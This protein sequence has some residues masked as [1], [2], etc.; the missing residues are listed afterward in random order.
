LLALV[1]DA[2]RFDFYERRLLA[3]AVDY[4]ALREDGADDVD[5]LRGFDDDARV[6]GAVCRALG[7]EE[8]VRGF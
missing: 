7:R 2:A 5:H 6:V 1:A 8:L 4:F 3:G